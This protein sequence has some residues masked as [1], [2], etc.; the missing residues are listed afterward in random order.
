MVVTDTVSSTPEQSVN[1]SSVVGSGCQGHGQCS[2]R[3]SRRIQIKIVPITPTYNILT[4]YLHQ[5]V[6]DILI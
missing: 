6:T 1:G 4:S 3:T 2:S 5:N